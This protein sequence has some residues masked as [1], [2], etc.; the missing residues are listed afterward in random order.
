MAIIYQEQ[1]SNQI[2]LILA[3]VQQ[4]S[5]GATLEEIKKAT[6]LN[7]ELRTLQRRAEKLITNEALKQTGTKRSTKYYLTQPILYPSIIPIQ[8]EKIVLQK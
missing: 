7:I 6:G 4:F 2:K 3:V 8:N 1:I 5:N